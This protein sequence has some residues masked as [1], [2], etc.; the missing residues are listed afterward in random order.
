MDN[1]NFSFLADAESSITG[2][3]TEGYTPKEQE[4][5]HQLVQ[6]RLGKKNAIEFESL[7]D[8]VVPPKMFFSM[9]K[10]PAVSIRANRMEF[11][12]PLNNS[13]CSVPTRCISRHLRL[14]KVISVQNSHYLSA[15]LLRFPKKGRLPLCQVVESFRPAMASAY[16]LAQAN[17]AY[18]RFSFFFRPRYTVF[19]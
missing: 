16:K 19:L 12:E 14:V 5:I 1:D 8:Y 9:I 4:L 11:R 10:K 3:K 15:F 2:D 7:D 17:I 6:E 18:S 13:L